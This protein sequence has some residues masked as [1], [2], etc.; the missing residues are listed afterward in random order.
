MSNDEPIWLNASVATN[1]SR[2]NR[3]E[4]PGHG[5][6]FK[7]NNYKNGRGQPTQKSSATK[8][9]E[10]CKH[11]FW[12]NWSK[13][14]H[15]TFYTP[16]FFRPY[17]N[18]RILLLRNLFVNEKTAPYSLFTRY[19]RD[20]NLVSISVHLFL[21]ILWRNNDCRLFVEEGVAHVCSV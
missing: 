6:A 1:M 5:N 12:N 20:V 7:G 13:K 16:S 21:K 19:D 11:L 15:N 9:H 14:W 4:I 10:F 3:A 18:Q 2:I 17:N 8:I